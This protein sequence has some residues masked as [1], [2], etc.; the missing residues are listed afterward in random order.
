MK[1]KT[2]AYFT[3]EIHFYLMTLTAIELR[4]ASSYYQFI[5]A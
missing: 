5:I 1:L 3:N 2:E 4:V